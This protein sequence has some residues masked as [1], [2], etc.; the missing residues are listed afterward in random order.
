MGTKI[1]SNVLHCSGSWLF[2]LVLQ[3]LV[4]SKSKLIEGIAIE[5]NCPIFVVFEVHLKTCEQRVKSH[6]HLNW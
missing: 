2:F 1:I 5:E 4:M 3:V 6:T